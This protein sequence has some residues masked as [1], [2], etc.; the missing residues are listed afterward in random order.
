MIRYLLY[1]SAQRLLHRLNLHYMP[2]C[3]PDGDTVIWCRWCGARYR[4][5]RATT[6]RPSLTYEQGRGVVGTWSE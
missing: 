1:R 4:V 5:P 2:P 3:H 6:G